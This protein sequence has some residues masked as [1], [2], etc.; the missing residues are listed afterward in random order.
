MKKNYTNYFAI[1]L[2]FVFISFQLLGCN[3]PTENIKD[4]VTQ[5]REVESFDGVIVNGAFNVFITQGDKQMIKVVAPKEVMEKIQTKVKTNKLVIGNKG[6]IKCYNDI[7]I[8]VTVT[9]FK[10]LIVSGASDVETQ[11]QIKSKDFKL[12]LSGAG[13]VD[14]DISCDDLKCVISGVGDANLKGKTS[15]FNCVISG[16]G[17]LKAY[18][19]IVETCK[20]I[21]T[22]AGDAKINV[23][24]EIYATVT[25]AGDLKYKG[26]A[27]VVKQ[28]ISGVGSIKHVD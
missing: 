25:G 16:A 3:Y 11:N 24:K 12:I 21:I 18:G 28:T 4:V 22:G 1:V 23:N 26:N 20:I 5:E 9:T 8:Y 13:D 2:G 14:M 10:S 6:K 7:K 19:F 27:E 15:T 17:D